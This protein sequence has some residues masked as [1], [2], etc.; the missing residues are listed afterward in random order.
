MARTGTSI[1]LD[2]GSQYLINDVLASVD[3]NDRYAVDYSLD[4]FTFSNLFT[5]LPSYGEVPAF[6]GGMD[7]MST[8]FTSNEY[9][10]GIDFAPITA[11]FLRFHATGGDGFYAVGELQAF[12]SPVP[13]P[14]TYGL[15]G[16]AG[17]TALAALRR[18]RTSANV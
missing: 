1:T 9:V 18:R 12:G 7:T 10:P 6:P 4:G 8:D 2:Y 3:N 11:R 13:E 14:S 15:I 5:I 17:L 16:A